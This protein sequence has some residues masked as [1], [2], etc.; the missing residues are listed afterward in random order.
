MKQYRINIRTK[1]MGQ[2]LLIIGI[3]IVLIFAWV[4][5]SMRTAIY[6]EKRTML[7]NLVG[8][9]LGYLE[10]IDSQ[11]KAGQ[12]SLEEAQKRA[13]ERIK[14]MRY[15]PE[16]K[17]YFWVN[18]FGPKMIMHPFRPDLEGKSLS[19]FK[20]P[21]GKALFVEMV[22]V[23]REKGK[24]AVEYVWQWKDD[25]N[26][27]EPKLSFVR[28]FTPWGW[29]IGTGAYVNDVNEQISTLRNRLLLV[30]VPIALVLLALL[31][32]PMRSLGGIRQIMTQLNG[33]SDEVA[34]ASN[35]VSS[36]SQNLAQ[37]A[38]EQAASLEETSS[39]LEELSS[40]TRQN[41]NNA[42]E[43]NQL[44]REMNRVV[45]QANQSMGATKNSMTAVHQA[46][47]DIAK[48]IKTIDEIAFQTNL[49]ALNAA[50]EAAR[51]GE[52]GLGFA[53][54]ADE[55]RSLA[56]RAATAARNTSEMIETTVRRIQ[57]GSEQ[58]NQTESA[59]HEV[60]SKSHKVG[61]LV[62]EINQASQEQAQGLDQINQAISQMDQVVQA[63]AANA[64]ES[65][66][67][68]EQLSAQAQMVREVVVR[69]AD[70]MGEQMQLAQ[71]LLSQSSG[72]TGHLE[73][74]ERA[75]LPTPG[76]QVEMKH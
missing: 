53:V 70:L 7:E 15:G 10:S 67:A 58:V 69:L 76:R 1:I 38:S 65:A 24:G 43:A 5:P 27:L 33:A 41:A 25:K 50:V 3:F 75:A 66:A 62:A 34:A 56:Q 37:G 59:F 30:I 68:S 32:I 73:H 39:S 35:Q 14:S 51:A 17:D 74:R 2:F 16:G 29:I 46:G 54:V 40:M 11:V 6:N 19:D 48:I 8:P 18:D 60:T 55:V 49:L 44:M 4:L 26:R 42:Q 28:A 64:E 21:K 63:N 36:T 13:Y 9:A 71:E 20:D 72:A 23:C 52:A 47:S 12:L 31:I 22:K 61:E 45:D 57:E